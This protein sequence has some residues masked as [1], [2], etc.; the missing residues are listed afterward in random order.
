MITECSACG[1]KRLARG[2]VASELWGW[3]LAFYRPGRFLA[4]LRRTAGLRATACIDC[5]HVQLAADALPE[6]R[7]LYEDQ[8]RGSLQLGGEQEDTPDG[9]R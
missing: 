2:A 3:P 1:S 6:L 5:G 9:E 8:R 4:R 7:D